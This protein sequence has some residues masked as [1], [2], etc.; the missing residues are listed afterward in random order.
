MIIPILQSGR[1]N[2]FVSGRTLT[3]KEEAVILRMYSIDRPGVPIHM[4]SCAFSFGKTEGIIM[5]RL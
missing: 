3:L 5:G 4:D 1:D 2:L